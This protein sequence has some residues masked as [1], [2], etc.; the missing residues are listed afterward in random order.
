MIEKTIEVFIPVGK[1]SIPERRIAPRAS[2]LE[3]GTLGLLDNGKEF[4][5]VILDRV[6]EILKERF[7]LKSV[8]R[9]KKDFAAKGSP[10][11]EEMA[12]RCTFVVNG[13]GH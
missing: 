9:F 5:S 11:T 2:S 7:E 4:S 3:G 13:V 6:E 12:G 1:T 8:L 10:F